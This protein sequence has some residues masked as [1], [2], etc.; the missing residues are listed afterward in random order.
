MK[1]QDNQGLDLMMR[2]PCV[3]RDT[4]DAQE[5][6]AM[7]ENDAFNVCRSISVQGAPSLDGR[8]RQ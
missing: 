2:G 1:T 5:K 3:V 7:S 8:Y 6:G 4:C